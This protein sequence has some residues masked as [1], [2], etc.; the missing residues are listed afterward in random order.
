MGDGVGILGS[1]LTKLKVV[2]LALCG[3]EALFRGLQCPLLLECCESSRVGPSFVKSLGEWRFFFLLSIFT[4]DPG[5]TF[6]DFAIGNAKPRSLP[7]LATPT[8][9]VKVVLYPEQSFP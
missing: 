4:S 6:L 5:S 7:L 1:M 8:P 3:V 9:H 2:L